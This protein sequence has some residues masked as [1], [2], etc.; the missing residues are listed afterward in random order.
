[1]PERAAGGLPGPGR[2]DLGRPTLGRPGLERSGAAGLSVPAVTPPGSRVPWPVL[3][4]LGV[5]GGIGL[6]LGQ[7][8]WALALLTGAGLALW[9]A[10][11]LLVGLTLLGAGLGAGALR[12]QMSQPDRL[13]P[14]T[15]A[16]VTLSGRWD[17]QFL[18]LRDPPARVALSPRPAVPAGQLVVSGRLVRPEGRRTPGGF[19]QAA[20]LR[21]QG[22]V[23]TPAPTRVLA[24]ARVRRSTPE[25]GPRGW[26]RRGLVAGLSPREGA[27]MQAIELGDRS[28]IGRETFGD[29]LEIQTAFARAGLAHLMALSGQNVA[30]LTGMLLGVL[31]LLRLRPAVR[32]GLCAAFLPVY[33]FGLVGPSPSITRAV[34]MGLSVLLALALGRGKPDPLGVIALA[35]VACLL[36]FPLWLTDLGF[37]LSFLAVLALTQSAALAARLPAR[38]PQALR[39]AVAATLLAELG[40]LPLIA[41]TFGQVPLVGLPANLL[42]GPVMAL[43][44]P[45]GFL[46][47]PLGPLGSVVNLAVHPLAAALL[48]LVE[49]LGRAPVISWGQISAPGLTAWALSL[50]AAWLWLRG[51]IRPPAALGTWLACALLTWGSA[52]LTPARELVFLDVGQGDATLL[53]LPHLTVLVDGGGSVG[54]DYDVGGRTVVPALRALGVHR[55]DVVVATHADTDHIEGLQSVLRALPVGELWIGHRKTGDPVLSGVLAVAAERGVPVREVRRGDQVHADGAALTVLWPSGERWSEEDNENSVALRLDS[56]GWRAALLGDLPSSVEAVVGTG[57]LNLLKAAHHGSRYSTGAELL[58]QSTPADTVISVGRNTYGH[59]H[60]DVLR[61]LQDSGVRVWRT[62]Q[63]GT[64]RWP[65]P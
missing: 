49:H 57:D 37:G 20:W 21:A 25:G 50:F 6:G 39:L 60:P 3:L 44:V 35:A 62:D 10:R 51:R 64:I 24:G 26:F 29:G 31:G 18:T 59:P 53:R 22:G 19:D 52:G 1:M 45:L 7:P 32:Y 65:L 28:A 56:G 16:L 4:A 14:W 34:V 42:A 27:L 30:L 11:P 47:G 43:L 40:T 5:M 63:S 41:S 17:G 2:Q 23:F 61:R 15:G 33:L 13:A 9:D 48:A 58:R 12:T 8:V 55:L 36:P 54:S 46:A 38:W